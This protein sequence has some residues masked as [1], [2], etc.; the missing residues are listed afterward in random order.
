MSLSRVWLMGRVADPSVVTDGGVVL[1]VATVDDTA[2]GE[3]L[4][5]HVVRCASDGSVPLIV[6]SLVLVAG[7]VEIDEHLQRAVVVASEITLLVEAREL[8]APGPSTGTHAS[9]V[10]HQR[11]GHFRR[12]GV[13][14]GRERLV[15]VRS[16]AV[17][18]P[19]N[20]LN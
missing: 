5:R 11:A 1:T 9:P 19:P 4:E 6:G 16:T 17:G 7:R 20:R 18:A 3:W 10:A 2:T 15:W 8:A 13:G 12:V 14:T